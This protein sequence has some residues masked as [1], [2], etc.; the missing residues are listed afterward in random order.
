M[1]FIQLTLFLYNVLVLFIKK[2]DILLYLCVDFCSLNTPT[3]LQ[4]T[5]LSLQSLSIY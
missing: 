5:G 1:S 2:Q 3:Y 4:S